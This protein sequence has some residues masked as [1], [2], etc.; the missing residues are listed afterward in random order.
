MLS[1]VVHFFEMFRLNDFLVGKKH[2]FMRSQDM[3]MLY[4]SL[5]EVFNT[6]IGEKQKLIHVTKKQPYD[7]CEQQRLGS[8]CTL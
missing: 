7:M 8:P 3:A 1:E 6:V 4:L 5:A 2:H